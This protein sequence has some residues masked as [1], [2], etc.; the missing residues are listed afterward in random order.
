MAQ[1]TTFSID[2]TT[3]LLQSKCSETF[4]PRLIDRVHKHLERIGKKSAEHMYGQQATTSGGTKLN[5]VTVFFDL[6]IN[7]QGLNSATF[8]T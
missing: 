5:N 7:P 3:Y 2:G 6:T 8:R 1:H 4:W